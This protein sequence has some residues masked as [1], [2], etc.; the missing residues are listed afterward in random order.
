MIDVN[1]DLRYDIWQEREGKNINHGKSLLRMGKD[2][3]VYYQLEEVISESFSYSI[4]I[5]KIHISL[6]LLKAY[7]DDALY[8]KKKC[9]ESVIKTLELSIMKKCSA[10][11]FLEERLYILQLVMPDIT[12]HQ[13]WKLLNIFEKILNIDFEES[14]NKLTDEAV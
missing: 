9:I 6:Y 2:D 7:T 8:S 13:V 14:S 5:D 11:P 1:P 12:L 10:I 3:S 4:E